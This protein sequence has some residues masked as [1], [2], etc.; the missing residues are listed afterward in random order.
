[1]ILTNFILF[2]VTKYHFSRCD[3][4]EIFIIIICVQNCN[5]FYKKYFS[6]LKNKILTLENW[7]F[8]I[9]EKKNNKILNSHNL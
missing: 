1:M 8:L 9:N 4:I 5:M 6:I 2:S 7:Y 3:I